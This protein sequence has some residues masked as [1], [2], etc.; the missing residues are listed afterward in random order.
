MAVAGAGAV[1][2]GDDQ[3]RRG[4]VAEQAVARRQA[5][6]GVDHHPHRVVAR[7]APHGELRVVVQHRARADQ[8]GIGQR[9]HAVG[10]EQV[11]L[12]ADPARGAARRGD[13][14]I[15]ALRQ[16]RDRKTA[17]RWHVDERPVER[18]E[19]RRPVLGR[20]RRRQQR[21]RA[22]AP[23]RQQRMPR[24]R[25]GRRDVRSRQSLAFHHAPSPPGALCRQKPVRAPDKFAR[26]PPGNFPNFAVIA[27]AAKQSYVT[28]RP[29][30]TL[31]VA[32]DEELS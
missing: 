27:S 12:A 31:R 26:G 4:A 9:A 19:R 20:R 30:T 11:L 6:L 15:E 2:G 17:L 21:G 23:P 28:V 24:H 18:E 32:Q 25:L 10:V 13:A 8:H 1:G 29:S 22:A 3:R 7:A 5:K 14:A 16:M